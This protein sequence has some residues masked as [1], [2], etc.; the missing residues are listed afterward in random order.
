MGNGCAEQ[1][2]RSLAENR[3][4]AR[5]QVCGGCAMRSQ[6]IPAYLC[7]RSCHAP[8]G[9][10]PLVGGRGLTALRRQPTDAETCSNP[11]RQRGSLGRWLSR[12]GNAHLNDRH[13]AQTGTPVLLVGPLS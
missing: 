7:Y 11:D 5:R 9:P 8:N 13:E 4:D 6:T 1:P 2:N 12:S 10:F 3:N